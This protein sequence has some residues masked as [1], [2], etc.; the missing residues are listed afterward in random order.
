MRPQIEVAEVAIEGAQ[1]DGQAYR[2]LTDP[3][4]PMMGEGREKKVRECH[5]FEVAADNGLIVAGGR[6]PDGND[7]GGLEPLVA[8][9]QAQ[10]PEGIQAVTAESGYYAGDAVAGLIRA[11]IDR[12]IPD[13]NTAGDLHRGQP[14]G[15]I[16][17]RSRGSV[18]LVYDAQA[19][20]YQCPEGNRLLPALHKPDCGQWVTEYRAQQECQGCPLPPPC[21]H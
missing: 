1:A 19:D 2:C 8:A 6:C 5:S 13:S 21:L 4:A 14:I 9:A 17:D 15:T 3:D 16:R 7:N 10:E 12:C 20:S 11:G 18:P